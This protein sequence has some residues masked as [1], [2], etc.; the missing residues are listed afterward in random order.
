VSNFIHR[1]VAQKLEETARTLNTQW[2]SSRKPPFGHSRIQPDL[3]KS[4]SYDESVTNT[5]S[6]SP[7]YDSCDLPKDS[8]IYCPE[9]VNTQNI[10]HL[11]PTEVTYLPPKF[12]AGSNGANFQAI[13]FYNSP[14]QRDIEN[15]VKSLLQTLSQRGTGQHY[16]PYAMNCTKGGVEE[17]ELRVFER[18]SAFRFV[19]EALLTKTF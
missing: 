12:N 6:P 7:F 10:V 16:C 4:E 8:T 15:R 17:G 1:S 19:Y 3:I 11:P 2:R 14:Q 13:D 5:P 18:N 9:L